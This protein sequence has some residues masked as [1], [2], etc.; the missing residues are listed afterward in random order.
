MSRPVELGFLRATVSRFFAPRERP[1]TEADLEQLYR[2]LTY[3]CDALENEIACDY[4]ELPT[5]M[6]AKHIHNGDHMS[7]KEYVSD[8]PTEFTV[9]GM[10]LHIESGWTLLY[11]GGKSYNLC[12][13]LVHVPSKTATD[14]LGEM[15]GDVESGMPSGE[16]IAKAKRR[17]RVADGRVYL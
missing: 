7:E 6:H 3:R 13:R 17:L 10:E 12:K 11:E 1:I 9:T 5:D 4:V 8:N 16:A 2:E 14:V 15:L